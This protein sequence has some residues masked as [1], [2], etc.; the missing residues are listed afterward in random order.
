LSGALPGL[1]SDTARLHADLTIAIAVMLGGWLVAWAGAARLPMRVVA[2]AVAAI[3]AVFLLGPPQPLTD[4][5]NYQVYGRMAAQ[6]FNP[7][8]HV[9][10]VAPHGPAYAL[11]NWHHL[12]SPYGPLFTL[13][14]EPL[15]LLSPQPAFWLWKLVVI[16]SALAI[17]ALVWWLAVRLGRSPQRA[18]VCVGLCPATLAIGVGG[19][20][21][22]GPAILCVL[23]AAACLVRGR[24]ADSSPWWDATAGALVVA[25]AGIKPSFAIVVPLIVVGAQKRAAALA[26]AAAMGALVVAVIA[27]AFDGALPA[28]GIQSRLVTPLSIPNLLGLAAGHG[29]ADASVRAVVREAL[30]VVVAAATA[31]VAFRRRWALGAMGIV[32]LAGALSLSWLMPWYLA[33]S[34]PFAALARPRALPAVA[35][36]SA[37]VCAWLLLG[38]LPELYPLLNAIGY[39]PTHYVPGLAAHDLLTGL[40]Q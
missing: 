39:H 8:T 26:G 18:V 4:V 29:G 33:W 13:L 24:D 21:N 40:V 14:S 1:T 12:P 11:S 2:A 27:F 31:L 20:H 32:L 35:A 36:V 15:G 9:P 5:F 19:F 23:A 7:Y 17:V 37:V 25:A 28:D 3:N 34:L 10:A 16:A 22:D 30:I 6:G 38:G